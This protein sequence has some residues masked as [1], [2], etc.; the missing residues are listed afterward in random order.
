MLSN[1]NF[2]KLLISFTCIIGYFNLYGTILSE[3][4]TM[5]NLNE[6]QNSSIA[7]IS[8]FTGLLSVLI[9]SLIIDKYKKYKLF[10]MI[11]SI[12]SIISHILFSLSLEYFKEKY[13]IILILWSCT[14]ICYLPIYTVTMDFVC[15]I[16]YPVGETISGGVLLS[17]AQ[18]AGVLSVCLFFLFFL[19]FFLF[20]LFLLDFD[21]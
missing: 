4:L 5:Y 8:Q 20:F 14:S 2:I 6:K 9:I 19:F 21:M 16:T 15:E 1:K 13:F 7:S 10:F 3:L 12:G 18:I 17:S 11:L